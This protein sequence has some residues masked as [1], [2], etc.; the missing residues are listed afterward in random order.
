MCG[1]EGREWSGRRAARRPYRAR[2]GWLAVALLG[3]AAVLLS[4]C[5]SSPSASTTS[6]GPPGSGPATSAASTSST[7]GSAAPTKGT[8]GGKPGWI[9]ADWAVKKFEAAGLS[10]ALADYYFNNPQTYLIVTQHDTSAV[11]RQLPDATHLQRFTSFATMKQAFASGSL[12][13]GTKAVMY[14][15]E[16]WSFTPA[17]EKA[18]P[19]NYARQARALVHQ[20]GMTFVFAPAVNL[21]TLTSAGSKSGA[22]SAAGSS[23]GSSTGKYAEYLNQGLAAHGAGVSDVL[24]I[25]T[26]Q[27]Q[28]TPTFQSF[29]SQA[30][31]QA[32][33]AN[34][35][36]KV[37]AGIGPGPNGRTV[38]AAD[39]LA[40]YEAVRP[41]VDG[42]WLNLPARNSQCPGCAAAQ[43][44]VAVDFLKS[45]AHRLGQ[46]TS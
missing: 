5:G 8:A 1:D 45:L 40:D 19:I 27:A 21:A 24:D 34:P 46:P 17:N 10:P 9:V 44:Q 18:A 30:I 29:A 39:I 41:V 2:A 28:A 20:H 22:G 23:A 4:A 42:Y 25:Q 37:F 33:A 3:T 12:T 35:R 26:Q 36:A 14:D 7:A 31:R 32:K 38:T 16:A 15:N 11:D 43:P 13:P 6:S